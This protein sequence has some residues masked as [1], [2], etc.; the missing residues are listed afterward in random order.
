M[1]TEAAHVAELARD[2]GVPLAAAAYVLALRRLDAAIT[3]LGADR[4][5]A[6]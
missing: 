3:S 6:A 1:T 2:T 4:D 5:F